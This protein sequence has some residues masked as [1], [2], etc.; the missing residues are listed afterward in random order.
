LKFVKTLKKS[1][2]M[3]IRSASLISLDG[4]HADHYDI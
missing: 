4:S 2:W 3:S 1:D